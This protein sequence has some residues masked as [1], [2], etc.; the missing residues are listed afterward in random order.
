MYIY[1][2]IYSTEILCKIIYF[3]FILVFIYV[4]YYLFL[5]DIILI[6]VSD[7]GIFVLKF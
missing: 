7:F 2:Y 4:N 5:S 6:I 1:K 3:Y